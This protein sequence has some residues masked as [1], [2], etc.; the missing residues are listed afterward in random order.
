MHS[1]HLDLLL[2]VLLPTTPLL[3]ATQMIRLRAWMHFHHLD[4]L[5]VVLLYS[6]PHL[7]VRG[8]L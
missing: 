5:L 3:P 7:L 8:H 1:H 4:L 6:M 2:A